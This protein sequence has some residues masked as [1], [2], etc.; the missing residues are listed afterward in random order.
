MTDMLPDQFLFWIFVDF[1]FA[2]CF[3]SCMMIVSCLEHS[4]K[5]IIGSVYPLRFLSFSYVFG[6]GNQIT[7]VWNETKI[8]VFFFNFSF[9]CS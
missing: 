8:V 5:L 9:T 6:I 2:M 4:R 3:Y 7:S 1:L